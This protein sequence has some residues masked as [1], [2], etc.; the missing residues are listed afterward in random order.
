[1]KSMLCGKT[2]V[3]HHKHFPEVID[4]ELLPLW[5]ELNKKLFNGRLNRPYSLIYK[6]DLGRYGG[7]CQFGKIENNNVG[8]AIRGQLKGTN[9]VRKVMAHELVHQFCYQEWWR[10][11]ST[12]R[13]N[14]SEMVDDK[15]AFFKYWLAYVAHLMD[16]T[17]S[18]L[19]S[20]DGK[21]LDHT[22]NPSQTTYIQTLSAKSLLGE[23]FLE[24]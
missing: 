1:M 14:M 23:A 20:Y 16:T 11:A 3:L 4:P 6:Y 9:E 18:D 7:I 10:L 2:K 19:A 8:I 12:I 15:S 22:G 17:Y 5:E 21:Y 24:D 13:V